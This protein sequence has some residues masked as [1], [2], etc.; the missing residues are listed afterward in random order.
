MFTPLA[1]PAGRQVAQRL[2][3]RL[4]DRA[5]L[6]QLAQGKSIIPDLGGNRRNRRAGVDLDDPVGAAAMRANAL[7][8][9]TH[10]LVSHIN[11]LQRRTVRS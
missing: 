6:N 3:Q 5:I 4:V 2:R 7:S 11:R 1:Q 9:F 8:I 10:F